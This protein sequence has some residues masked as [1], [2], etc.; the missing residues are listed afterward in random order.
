MLSFPTRARNAGVHVRAD[1]EGNRLPKYRLN[2]RNAR[3][4][5]DA[6]PIEPSCGCYTCRHYSRAYLHHLFRAEEMLG[7]TL[8]T[9][10]N[11]HFIAVLCADIRQALR[12]DTYPAL[13]AAWL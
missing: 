2:L 1:D 8:A 3:F 6:R 5:H 4:R 12:D 7:S 11:L 10:H 9:I 13:R